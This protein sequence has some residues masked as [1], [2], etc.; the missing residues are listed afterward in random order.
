MEGLVIVVNGSFELNSQ[1]SR[2]R[3][4][5]DLDGIYIRARLGGELPS[6]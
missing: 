5:L 6:K 4:H 2:A 1:Q 3:L